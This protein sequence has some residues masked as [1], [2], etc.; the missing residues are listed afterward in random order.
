MKKAF[1]PFVIMSALIFA[2]T[3]G[4]LAIYTQTQVLRGQLYTRV[5]LFKANEL[6]SSTNISLGALSLAPGGGEKELYRF[7]LT[8]T[9]DSSTISDYDMSVTISSHGMASA[10]SAMDGLVFRLYNISSESGSPVASTSGGELNLSGILFRAGVKQTI[11]YKVTA[12]WKDTGASEDQTAI[13]KSGNT[14]PVYLS[15]QAAG[16]N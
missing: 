15:A 8:N 14:F 4:S 16:G 9:D 11:Q 2:M 5:F 7:E 3:T 10:L 12:E 1:I 6:D 13:A